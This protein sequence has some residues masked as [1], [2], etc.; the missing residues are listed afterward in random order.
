MPSGPITVAHQ[1]VAGCR[2][3]AA[4]T[5]RVSSLSSNP[6]PPAS[7]G[8]VSQGG[9][10]AGELVQPDRGGERRQDAVSERR[11]GRGEA[12]GVQGDDPGAGFVDQPGGHS[13]QRLRQAR[14]QV[15]SVIDRVHGLDRP[16]QQLDRELFAWELS[17]PAVHGYVPRLRPL[18]LGLPAA[19]EL[20]DHQRLLPRLAVLLPPR[21]LQHPD[22]LV[23]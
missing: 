8:V 19:G 16:E 6:Q 2:E 13:R 9:G 14:G 22:Q 18:E 12:A 4:T 20:G 3:A 5:A 11:V 23:V 7:D 21:R 10:P 1:R 17:R 15:G